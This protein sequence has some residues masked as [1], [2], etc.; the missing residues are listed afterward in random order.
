MTGTGPAIAVIYTVE[1]E[2]VV[3][4]ALASFPG[5][6]VRTRV[7]TS[8]GM[9]LSEEEYAFHRKDILGGADHV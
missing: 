5:T 4:A 1:A 7:S 3:L 2:E 9:V 8:P 6:I